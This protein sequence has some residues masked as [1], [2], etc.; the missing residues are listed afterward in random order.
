VLAGER[1]YAQAPLQWTLRST[2]EIAAQL[3]HQGLDVSPSTAGQLMRALGYC[4]SGQGRRAGRPKRADL[5]AQYQCA[6]ETAAAFSAR[7]QP[8]ISVRAGQ[9]KLLGTADPGPDRGDGASGA[10]ARVRPDL[11]VVEFTVEAIRRWWT[12]VSP[13][14]FPDA[15]QLLVCADTFGP[16]AKTAEGWRYHLARL[17]HATGLEITVQRMPPGSWRWR[18]C[19]PQYCYTVTLAPRHQPPVCCQVSVDLV[20]TP[21]PRDPATAAGPPYHPGCGCRY[22]ARPQPSAT[23]LPGHA[24]QEQVLARSARPGS[25]RAASRGLPGHAEPRKPKMAEI[26]AHNIARD[27]STRKLRPGARLP[28]ETA[29]LSRFSVSRS[30]LREALRLLELLGVIGIRTGAG[31]GPVVGQVTSADFGTTT[32]F[33]YHL[34]GVTIRELLE[35]RWILEP[36]LV[37]LTADRPDPAARGQ[38]R[39]YMNSMGSDNSLRP[40]WQAPRDRTA[41]FHRALIETGN[42][43]LDLFSHSLQDVWTARQFME[44]FPWQAAP[45]HNDDHWLIAQAILGGDGSTAESLMRTHMDYLY[46]FATANWSG[47][48]DEVID[49]H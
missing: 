1:R 15:S 26:V 27:I 6:S 21:E 32:T 20:T 39:S 18:Q 9:T 4:T 48:M 23:P 17:A 43:P 31:G 44:P 12:E 8:V 10:W 47:L 41:D 13:R 40:A 2:Y 5:D 45:H 14:D 37:R 3:Q 7:S 30:S 22:T 38:L 19:Q 42:A 24:G 36:A 46:D 16:D 11:G 28:S 49:W 29:A 33:Y 25:G 34:I 35:A